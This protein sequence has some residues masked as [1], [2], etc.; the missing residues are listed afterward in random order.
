MRI[1]TKVGRL[2]AYG[3]AAVATAALLLSWGGLSAV[4]AAVNSAL[5]NV[6]N[7]QLQRISAQAIVRDVNGTELAVV[8][9]RD[10]GNG[11][12]IVRATAKKLPEGFHGFHVHAVGKCDPKAVDA[13]GKVVPFMSAGAHFDKGGSNKH[14]D[15]S[16]DLPVLLVNG[17]GTGS[18]TVTTT[19][20]SINDLFPAGGTSVV[21]HAAADN[22]ANIP[23]R[24]AG[25]DGQTGPDAETLKTGDAGG[26]IGCG[27][28][29]R[30]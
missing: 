18:T 15:Q 11:R 27:V 10:G 13:N 16:G 2:L 1:R 14:P 29:R 9:F 20:F 26:R 17:D 30:A 25:P 23:T 24:F 3:S 7:S 4:H 5:T 28:I 22:F 19:R 21:V 6:A 8:T 12:V